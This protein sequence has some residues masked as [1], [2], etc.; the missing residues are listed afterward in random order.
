MYL[1]LYLFFQVLLQDKGRGRPLLRGG[2]GGLQPGAAVAGQGLGGVSPPT[3][4][5]TNVDRGMVYRIYHLSFK[6]SS[7]Y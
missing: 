7:L 5:S 3:M 2:E 4:R 6:S 1:Y